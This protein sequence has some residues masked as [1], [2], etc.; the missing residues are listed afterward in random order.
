MRFILGFRPGDRSV[1]GSNRG[2]EA[3]F[4]ALRGM[5]KTQAEHNWPEQLPGPVAKP[6]ENIKN[7]S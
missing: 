7:N 5:K 1:G 3:G 4:S 6:G 2:W